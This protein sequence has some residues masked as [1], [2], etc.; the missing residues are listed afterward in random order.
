M[1]ILIV[2]S[3]A[4]AQ[5]SN[6]NRLDNVALPKLLP[7][8]PEP[9]AFMRA[10]FANTNMSTG[11]ASAQVPLY[12]IKVRDFSFPISLSYST[13]GLKADEPTTRTG[14][15]WVL[16]AI[17]MVTRSV[18][19]VPDEFGMTDVSGHRMRLPASS[20]FPGV[21]DAYDPTLFGHYHQATDQG[22][23]LDTEVDEFNFHVNGQKG[24]FVLD[25]SW[26]PK[27]TNA[28]NAKITMDFSPTAPISG[29]TI[30]MED[31]VA[32]HFG[33]DVAL[34]YEQTFATNMAQFDPNKANTRTALF[35]D[36]ITLVTGEQIN[37][38][39]GP[40]ISYTLATGINQSLTVVPP[41]GM[42]YA[43]NSFLDQQNNVSYR[44][45]AIQSIQVSNGTNVNFTY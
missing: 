27:S 3:T 9:T 26:H 23:S 22:A 42:G 35:L 19:G 25:D 40:E 28:T 10:A 4:S 2:S 13:Q 8:S 18:K 45:R 24:S 43:Q 17:G 29:V 39:Y 31:G 30:V 32:Y 6:Q 36:K 5:S 1:I 11:A 41:A 37:F 20:G 7:A 21:W 33:S 44:T 16:N 38:V 15:G 14:L 12:T 34:A